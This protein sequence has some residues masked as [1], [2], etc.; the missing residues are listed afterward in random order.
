METELKP[1]PFCGDEAHHTAYIDAY[2]AE[3]HNVECMACGAEAGYG[4]STGGLSWTTKEAAYKQWNTR[5]ESEKVAQLE[6]DK[7]ELVD[8]LRNLVNPN[9][10]KKDIIHIIGNAES[11][12]ERMK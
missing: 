8:L 11:L 1:C 10:C 5:A 12:L 7:A 6:K 4:D 9:N 2:Q 3:R